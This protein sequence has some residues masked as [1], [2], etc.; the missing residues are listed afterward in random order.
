L[1]G[2]RVHP[3]CAALRAYALSLY[4]AVLAMILPVLALGS[5]TVSSGFYAW[6]VLGTVII[7]GSKLI[8]SVTEHTWGRFS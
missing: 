7:L 2:Y 8:W 1:E 3:E 6:V 5:G 4:G